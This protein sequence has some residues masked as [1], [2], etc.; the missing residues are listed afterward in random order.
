MSREVALDV[1]RQALLIGDDDGIV[2]HPQLVAVARDHPVL[3]CLGAGALP[4]R[5]TLLGNP[6]AIVGMNEREKDLPILQPLVRLVAEHQLDLRADEVHA[7]VVERADVCESRQSL[8]QPAVETLG[9][10]RL[11]LRLC[12]HDVLRRTEAIDA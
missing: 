10:A 2:V 9:V 7:R 4:E 12:E 11:A 6:L 5:A 3:E 8:D 1:G